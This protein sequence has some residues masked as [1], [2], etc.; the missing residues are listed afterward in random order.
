MSKLF[1]TNTGY[2][3]IYDKESVLPAQMSVKLFPTK[4]DTDSNSRKPPMERGLSIFISKINGSRKAQ[5]EVKQN[6]NT[7]KFILPFGE[8]PSM[9]TVSG[10]VFA[11]SQTIQD[12]TEK[13]D[14]L[15]EYLEE[16]ED[17]VP[18][19]DSDPVEPE[20]PTGIAKFFDTVKKGIST[21]KT[22]ATNA[23]SGVTGKL[24]GVADGANDTIAGIKDSIDQLSA[25][26]AQVIGSI[27]SSLGLAPP[28]PNREA[29]P[30]SEDDQYPLSF[31]QLHALFD[32]MHAGNRSTKPIIEIKT[33][34]VIFPGRLI[35]MEYNSM[36]SETFAGF[37]FTMQFMLLSKPTYYKL[38]IER[39]IVTR[40]SNS[41]LG[42]V[43]GALTEMGF[44]AIRKK[45]SHIV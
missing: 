28:P 6:L 1:T 3:A 39:P 9:V 15:L 17:V 24:K 8:A 20:E 41:V 36:E 34:G 10:V 42:Q 2:V 18:T 31:A 16:E 44:S 30:I 32:I 21:G 12:K 45:R 5:V 35:G 13:Y 4:Y 26:P 29:I 23:I 38:A 25:F 37:T 43:G 7:D 40:G 33:S 19:A 27:K 11:A 14:D 22:A